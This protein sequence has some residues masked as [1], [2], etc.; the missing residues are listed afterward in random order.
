MEENK[1]K[2]VERKPRKCPVCGSK[3]VRILY[4]EPS[5]E[6]LRPQTVGNLSSADAASGRNLLTGNALAAT[7]SSG[8]RLR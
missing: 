8:K 4:G 1:V 7:S 6:V 3:V 5:H 2:E